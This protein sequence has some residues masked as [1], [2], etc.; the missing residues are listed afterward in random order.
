VFQNAGVLL[1]T[2]HHFE[3][4]DIQLSPRKTIIILEK[5]ELE[6]PPR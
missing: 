6:S 3:F 2:V 5:R 4:V 1:W